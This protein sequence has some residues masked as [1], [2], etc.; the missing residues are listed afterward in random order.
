MHQTFLSLHPDIQACS[1]VLNKNKE[2]KNLK[3]IDNPQVGT[4]YGKVK[5]QDK[6]N[7]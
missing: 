4:V 1:G 6:A 7:H 3:Q 2:T 5:E